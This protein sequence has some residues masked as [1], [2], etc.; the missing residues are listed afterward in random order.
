MDNQ[1]SQRNSV[2]RSWNGTAM[3][4]LENHR[5]LSASVYGSLPNP[6]ANESVF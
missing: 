3:G 5:R 2:P 4:N 6:G 1:W